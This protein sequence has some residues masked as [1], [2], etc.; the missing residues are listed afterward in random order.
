MERIFYVEGDDL[1][2]VNSALEDGAKV[3]QIV[4]TRGFNDK[5]YERTGYAYIV[6]EYPDIYEDWSIEQL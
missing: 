4:A 3:K 5:S 2:A 6:L 1:N